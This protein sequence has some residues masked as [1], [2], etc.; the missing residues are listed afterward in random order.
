MRPAR[1]SVVEI[2]AADQVRLKGWWMASPGEPGKC[3]VL[4]HGIADTHAG[5]AGFAP[6]FLERGYSVLAPDS[7]AHGESGG[8]FVTYGLLEKHDL[9]AW[10][11]WMNSQGCRRLYALGESL[12]ASVLIQA[13]AIEPVFSAVVV[14]CPFADLRDIAEY[15]MRGLLG[16]PALIGAPLAGFVVGSGML[17]ARVANGLDF[18]QVSPV[19]SIARTTTPALLIHG[20]A[21]EQTP[22]SHSVRLAAANPRNP[23][24]LVP[25]AGHTGAAAAAPEEFR[26]RVLAWF[27]GH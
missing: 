10:A 27:A 19:Q 26:T 21:D 20:I 4:L 14:E 7:R 23:L 2:F 1:A 6:M 24:W 13:A 9:I 12:G 17:Y 16:V 5:A 8:E 11:H 3:V 25:N 18:R 22:P 15:R